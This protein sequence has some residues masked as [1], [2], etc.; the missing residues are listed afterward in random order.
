MY[1]AWITNTAEVAFL[2][3]N[4]LAGANHVPVFSPWHENV[5][6][7]NEALNFGVFHLMIYKSQAETELNM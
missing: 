2:N 5:N 1:R 4:R 7:F 6:M 3:R